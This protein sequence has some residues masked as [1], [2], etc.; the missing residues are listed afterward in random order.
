MKTDLSSKTGNKKR[1]NVDSNTQFSNSKTF[2]LFFFAQEE[3]NLQSSP[4][5]LPHER[6]HHCDQKLG[7]IPSKK[8]WRMT[9]GEFGFIYNEK[10]DCTIEPQYNRETPG[11]RLVWMRVFPEVSDRRRRYP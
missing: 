1:S 10:Y 8:N 7:L 9:N 6:R 5:S 11:Q 3:M 2:A 4:L